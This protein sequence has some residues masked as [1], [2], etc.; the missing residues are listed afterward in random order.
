MPGQTGYNRRQPQGAHPLHRFMARF[1]FQLSDPVRD[2]S[3]RAPIQGGPAGQEQ[4]GNGSKTE[5]FSG[6]AQL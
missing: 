1:L 6:P 3:K 2:G 4:G 5:Y